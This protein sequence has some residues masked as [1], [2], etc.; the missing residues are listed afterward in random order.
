MSIG[1][2]RGE[3]YLEPYSVEWEEN[4]NKQSYIGFVS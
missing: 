2:K 3:V 1:M 4:A